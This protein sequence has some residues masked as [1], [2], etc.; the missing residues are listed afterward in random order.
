MFLVL[1]YK[2]DVNKS[3]WPF[4]NY[5][6]MFAIVAVFVLKLTYLGDRTKPFELTGWSV[7][8]MFGYMWLHDGYPH[9]IGNL[10]FIWIFGNALCSK[11]G[12]ILYI[13]LYIATGLLAAVLHLVFDDR[14]AVGASGAL[15]GVIGA[16]FVFYPFNSIKCFF[17]FLAYLRCFSVA[18]FWIILLKVALDVLGA[19]TGYMGGTAYFAHIGGFVAGVILAMVLLMTKLVARDCMDDAIVRS[20]KI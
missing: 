3:R 7:R 18:G 12:N 4:A 5:L 15:Y 16:Y 14:T 10:I 19:V 13:P 9:I 17:W 8:E 2:V 6:V 1:P 11:V 20:I